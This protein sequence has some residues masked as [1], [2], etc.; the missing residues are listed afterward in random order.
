MCTLNQ[1]DIGF[2]LFANKDIGL[3]RESNQGVIGG[4]ST[5]QK[6]W[7]ETTALDVREILYL[8]ASQTL[9]SI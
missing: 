1:I 4:L 7:I 2:E 9:E 5:E 8:Y 3:W 6:A